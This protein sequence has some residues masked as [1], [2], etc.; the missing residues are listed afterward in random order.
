MASRR[1][2]L[3]LMTD[4]SGAVSQQVHRWLDQP[5]ARERLIAATQLGITVVSLALGAVGENTF[6]AWLEPYFHNAHFPAWLQF[7]DGL[8]PALPLVLSLIIVTSLHVVLGEQVPKVAVLRAPERFMLSAA[9]LMRAFI[10]LFRWFIGLLDWA[11]RGVLRIFGLPATSPH[12]LAYSTEEIKEMVTGP[13]VEGAL[14]PAER[15]MLSAVIDFGEMV[16]RQVVQ[17][18]TE[19]IAVEADD[20]IEEVIRLATEN[21]ITKIPVYEDNLDQVI[22]V[23]HVRDILARIAA[24]ESQ[25]CCARDLAREALFVPETISVSQL[26]REFRARR[27]HLAIVL[28]EFGGTTGLVTLEDLLEEIVGEVS[29]P[30]DKQSPQIQTQ[31]DG[32]ALVDG[33]TLIDDVNEAL[34]LNL[35]NAHYDTMAGYLLDRLGHIPKEGESYT[36][37][38]H[39]L[40][41]SVVQMERLRI[42]QVRVERG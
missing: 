42:A 2:R 22:G 6:E 24:G 30:F 3:D 17:P 29:D 40:R 15:E 28:D 20:P 23:I 37:A 33:M 4:P 16:V 27:M 19:I 8:L 18:R 21:S 10:W 11:T 1:A 9:P 36:D 39:G 35:L 32:S 31:P 14:E 25:Q 26:L 13:E 5:A 34:G 38:E 12:A 41:L 7:L